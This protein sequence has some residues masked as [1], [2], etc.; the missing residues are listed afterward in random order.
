MKN[1]RFVADWRNRAGAIFIRPEKKSGLALPQ[2]IHKRYNCARMP[3]TK[4]TLRDPVHRR[5][6]GK[7]P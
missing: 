7:Q 6:G 4:S 3:M 1:V 5:Y 2:A